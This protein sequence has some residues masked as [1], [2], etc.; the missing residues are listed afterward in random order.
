MERA[1]ELLFSTD[2]PVLRLAR[3][4]GFNTVEQLEYNFPKLVG[5]SATQYRK[6]PKTNLI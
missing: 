4:C 2:G 5:M 3:G 1:K 6:S